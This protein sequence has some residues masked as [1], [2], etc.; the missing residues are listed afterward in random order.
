MNLVEKV[1]RWWEWMSGFRERRRPRPIASLV[2]KIE[3]VD[4]PE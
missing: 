4:P 3:E 2:S 1:K